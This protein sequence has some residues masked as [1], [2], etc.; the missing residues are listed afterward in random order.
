MGNMQASD[1]DNWED[2]KKVIAFAIIR[3]FG[4]RILALD[5]NRRFSFLPVKF[6]V[7]N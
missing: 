5:Q 2:P 7:F 3:L 4:G 1:L 6:D